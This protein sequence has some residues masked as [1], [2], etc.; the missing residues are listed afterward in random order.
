MKLFIFIL[1]FLVTESFAQRI[2]VIKPNGVKTVVPMAGA[3]TIDATGIVSQPGTITLTVD[4][5]GT[6][7]TT[8]VKGYIQVP[9]ACTI[10]GWTILA[11][12][13]G[14]C[15]IDVWRDAYAAYPPTVLDTIT[16]SAKPTLTA[17]NKATVSNPP[18]WLLSV[19]AGDILGFNIDSVSTVTKLTLTLSVIHQ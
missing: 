3:A 12:E 16:A 10:T 17:N 7:L 11:K 18:G 1:F 5:A 13:T 8:G 15:V 2:E 14:N 4:G 19:A 6:A 9:Y